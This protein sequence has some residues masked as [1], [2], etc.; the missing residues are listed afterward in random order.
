MNDKTIESQAAPVDSIDSFVNEVLDQDSTQEAIETTPTESATVTE[1]IATEETELEAEKPSG[2][3]FQK[4]IDKVTKD[5]YA[6]KRRADDLQ[7][8]I[9]AI[10]A[11]NKKDALVKPTLESHDYDEEAFDSATLQYNI[12]QGV[13]AALDQKESDVKAEKQKGAGEKVL[14]DFN[15]NITALGKEDFEEKQNS[16]PM[17]PKGVAEAI[18]Q[19]ENGA[20]M[21]YHLGSNPETASNIASMSPLMAMQELGKLSTKLSTKP[22]I[23]LSA[24]PE[25]ISP[26]KAGSALNSNIDDEMS[27]ADWMSKYG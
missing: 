20:E 6:E 19:S 25:P 17:L 10:E 15:A 8:R 11:G 9:D 22:E 4:R 3:G 16:I 24:A 26:V 7:K 2:D 14:S 5:K 27:M 13:Q 1:D 12:D 18:M 23:K 21:V